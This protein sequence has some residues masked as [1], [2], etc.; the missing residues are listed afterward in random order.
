MIFS[1]KR[2]PLKNNAGKGVL[3]MKDYKD[4]AAAFIESQQWVEEDMDDLAGIRG[5]LQVIPE[6]SVGKDSRAII[7]TQKDIAFTAGRR[8][9]VNDIS[10]RVLGSDNEIAVYMNND[11]S[12]KSATKRW[13]KII[14]KTDPVAVLGFKDAYAKAR[15]KLPHAGL[16]SL[17]GWDWGYMSTTDKKGR[18]VMSV[19][20]R[21]SFDPVSMIDEC[22][23]QSMVVDVR[24]QEI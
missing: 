5:M 24:A 6:E 23:S 11:G 2:K 14:G 21:F 18:D 1:G 9:T 3:V 7:K 10:V 13:R 17:A 20:Y 16:Y 15:D 19:Y 8:V 22:V 4:K 12:V